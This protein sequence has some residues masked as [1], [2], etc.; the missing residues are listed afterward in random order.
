[1]LTVCFSI[2]IWYTNFI[3]LLPKIQVPS[4]LF[5]VEKF[6]LP[7]ILALTGYMPSS[8]WGTFT[9]GDGFGN[10]SSEFES[11]SFDRLDR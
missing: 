6:Y 2:D 1:M 7:E 10:K 8:S 11:S 5:S 4:R 9:S 3:N